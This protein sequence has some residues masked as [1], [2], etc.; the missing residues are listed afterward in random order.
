MPVIKLKVLSVTE[1][2]DTKNIVDYA[3]FVMLGGAF[4]AMF[5]SFIVQNNMHQQSINNKLSMLSDTIYSSFRNEIDD[6]YTQLEYYDSSYYSMSFPK[7]TYN[8]G[9]KINILT[10]KAPYYPKYYPYG[11]YYF[12]TDSKGIQTSY[13]TLINTY[14]KLSDL[15]SRDYVNKKDEWFYPGSNEKKFRLQS[16]VSITSGTVKAAISKKGLSPERPVVAVSTKMYSIIN[17]ILPI[18]YSFCIIDKTGKV[19]F[20]SNQNMNLKEN[21][22]EEC[23][24]NKYLEAAM[25]AN[26]SKTISVNYYNNPCR[27]HIKRLDN[28]PLYLITILNKKSEKS[29]QAETI[30]FTLLFIGISMLAIFLQIFVLLIIEMQLKH[31]FSRNL[32]V[33]LTM[34][35][36]RLNGMY[37]YLT[38]LNI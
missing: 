30:T 35:I 10:E 6:V 26:M 3:L 13:L 25:Y 9:V 29:F 36:K 22:V 31:T 37:K 7:K 23:N 17:T 16:I 34:P 32:L 12:W 2:L 27:I 4:M 24:N 11:D 33:K 20:H 18:S 38:Q 28:L 1:Q 21:F 19:W 5:L 14:G 8:S 15:S